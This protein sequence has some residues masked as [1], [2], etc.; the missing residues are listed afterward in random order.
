MLSIVVELDVATV[1][2]PD[3]GPLLAVVGETVTSGHPVR[4]ERMGRPEIKN[5]ILQDKQFDPV[6]RD[7]EIRDLYNAEDAFD[8]GRDYLGAYRA[9]LNANLA[10]FDRL[11]G[12]TDWPPDDQGVHPLTELL[13]ADFLV[14]DTSKP[15]ADGSFLEIERAVLAGRPHTTCG[16]RSLDD[17][18]VDILYTL[19][20]GGLDGPRI[21]DGVDQADPAGQ[22]A[23]SPT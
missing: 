11:D 16:G 22:P 7:L 10:F 9:R 23:A 17:D 14:V 20:V 15:F 1:L 19:L 3:A 2:G 13:L 12:R 4:L 5:F 8:L 18:I 21:S 6:N